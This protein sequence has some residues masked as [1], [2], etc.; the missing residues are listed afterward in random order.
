MSITDA[1]KTGDLATLRRLLDEGVNPD[2]VDWIDT[3]ALNIAL[4]AGQVAAAKLLIERGASVRLQIRDRETPLIE[5]SQ[6]GNIEIMQM[7]LNRGCDVNVLDYSRRTALS[8][9]AN[10]GKRD[11]VHLLLKAGAEVNA[12]DMVGATP[13]MY[14]CD[15]GNI[16]I[17]KLLLDHGAEINITTTEGGYSPL[18][19]ASD[20]G[21]TE[22]IKLLKTRKTKDSNLGKD[23][24][25]SPNQK[26]CF[27]ATASCG[28]ADAPDVV[29]LQQFRDQVLMH[30]ILGRSLVDIYEIISPRI[31]SFI[32]GSVERRRVVKKWVIQPAVALAN[33]ILAKRGVIDP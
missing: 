33:R 32:E 12:K 4:R 28:T 16:E 17:V 25:S 30:F 8:H 15:N 19:C 22:I 6:L 31:A 9:A 29:R 18:K 23:I 24:S 27:I 21:H 13:L 20:K 7:I 14:A 26:K 2:A 10:K 11:I 5:A 3:P 1:A